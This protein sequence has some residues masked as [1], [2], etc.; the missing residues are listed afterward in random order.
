MPKYLVTLT[1][2]EKYTLEV[3]A[4]TEEK[5]VEYARDLDIDEY[6]ETGIT[7]IDETIEEITE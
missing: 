1:L 3:E 4:D 5:A 2:K 6:T 7:T